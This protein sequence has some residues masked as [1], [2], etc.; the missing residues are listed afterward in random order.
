VIVGIG[1]NRAAFSLEAIRVVTLRVCDLGNSGLAFDLIDFLRVL[2]PR[3]LQANWTVSSFEDEF[4]ATGEGAARLE[5]LAEN[6]GSITGDELLALAENTWQVI[7]GEFVGVLPDG[8]GQPLITIRAVDS[9]YY[10]IITSEEETAATI[11][12]HFNDVRAVGVGVT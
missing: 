8:S 2:A 5:E 3:S 1:S 12:A 6:G 7:W 4:E 10:E 11:K 9:S